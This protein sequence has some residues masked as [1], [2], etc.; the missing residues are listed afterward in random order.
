M[1]FLAA[2]PLGL[3]PALGGKAIH[4]CAGVLEDATACLSSL[5]FLFTSL[6]DFQLQ[7]NLFRA[8]RIPYQ[9]YRESR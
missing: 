6:P 9:V 1:S 4:F 7:Q 8:V 3:A 5:S 2:V